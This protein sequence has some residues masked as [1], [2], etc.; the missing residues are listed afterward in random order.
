MENIDRARL[1]QFPSTASGARTHEAGRAWLAVRALG[2]L[3][4][5][6]VGVVHLQQY[7]KLYWAIPTIGTLFVLNFAGA[8]AIA[9]GLLAPVER[10]LGASL[11]GPGPGPPR[12]GRHRAGRDLI[13]VPRDQRTDSPVRLHGAGLRPDRHSGL[14]HLGG[15]D[16]GPARQP[17][18]EPVSPAGRIEGGG[19]RKVTEL[20]KRGNLVV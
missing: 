2:A 12:A 20:R 7:L 17:I 13:R 10:L 8:A 4:V 15:S 14:S 3:A 16:G 6:T 19:R 1:G 11:G 5:L 9:T 18:W